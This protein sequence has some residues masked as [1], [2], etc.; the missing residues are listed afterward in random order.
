VTAPKFKLAHIWTLTGVHH[1]SE[2]RRHGSTVEDLRFAVEGF[3]EG[4]NL[5]EVLARLNSMQPVPA[6]KAWRIKYPARLIFPMARRPETAEE[7]LG[8]L[9]GANVLTILVDLRRAATYAI[10]L[11]RFLA[12][13]K[14]YPN[15]RRPAENAAGTCR[16]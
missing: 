3:D 12:P 9:R 10:R 14:P 11:R 1:T 8:R 13:G 5:R 2:T 7:R 4:D 16:R 15:F 6:Y